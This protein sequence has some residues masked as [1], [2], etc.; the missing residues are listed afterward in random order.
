MQGKP[1]ALVTAGVTWLASLYP[2]QSGQLQN[3]KTTQ[4]CLHHGTPCKAPTR[5]PPSADPTSCDLTLLFLSDVGDLEQ[6]AARCLRGGLLAG[7]GCVDPGGLSPTCAPNYQEMA[8]T[9][10]LSAPRYL[11]HGF[12]RNKSQT[13]LFPGVN[14]Q[15]TIGRPPRKAAAED[16]PKDSPKVGF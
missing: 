1:R 8:L 10:A 4:T 7:E 5:V 9:G 16:T 6:G 3:K 15:G 12:L 2:S 14:P 11:G 13:F